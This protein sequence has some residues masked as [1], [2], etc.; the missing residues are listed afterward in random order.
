MRLLYPAI[1]SLAVLLFISCPMSAQKQGGTLRVYHRDSPPSMSIY[2]ETTFSTSM[3]MMGVFNNLIVFDPSQ[4]QNRLD[5]I[6]PDLAES[7]SLSQ[8][9]KDLTFKLRS[10]VKWHD[11]KSFTAND[12]KCSWDLLLG[13]EKE[14]LMNTMN[15]WY[16]SIIIIIIFVVIKTQT[17]TRLLKHLMLMS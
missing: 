16:S 12:V 7:W 2:E 17:S 3:P 13:K 8:D 9:G 10:G 14:K 1:T 15:S 11:G 6:L 5:N 4:A